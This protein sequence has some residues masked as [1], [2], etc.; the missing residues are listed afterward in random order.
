M[1]TEE[2]YELQ[3]K[4]SELELELK[5]HK[6][7][8]LGLMSELGVSS[9]QE[10]GTFRRVTQGEL[11]KCPPQSDEQHAFR[12]MLNQLLN[13]ALVEASSDMKL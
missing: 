12:T 13:K 5:V 6:A 11:S 7:L 8:I 2:F 4:L 10:F 3:Q 1:D 9:L